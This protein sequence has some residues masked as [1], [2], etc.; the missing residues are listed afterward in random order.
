[1]EHGPIPGAPNFTYEE[2]LHSDTAVREGIQNIP[3]DPDVWDNMEY[4]ARTV[5]IFASNQSRERW[6]SVYGI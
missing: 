5:L 3:D 1:M 4:L 2:L 6:C